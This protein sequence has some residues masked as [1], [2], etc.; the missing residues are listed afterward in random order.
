MTLHSRGLF[1]SSAHTSPAHLSII[2]GA[3]ILESVVQYVA[4]V[5]YLEVGGCLLFRSRKCIASTGI[6]IGTSMVVCYTEEVCYWEGPLLEVPVDFHTATQLPIA[7]P[8]NC[9]RSVYIA[10]ATVKFL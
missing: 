7:H 5:C 3:F 4:L 2:G 9:H 8:H 6:A 10:N 1:L